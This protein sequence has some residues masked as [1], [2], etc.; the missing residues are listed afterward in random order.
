LT[1]DYVQTVVCDY[2]QQAGLKDYHGSKASVVTVEDLTN[3]G[4]DVSNATQLDQLR[5][6][7]TIPCNDVK[8]VFINM[9]IGPTAQIS[10]QAVWYSA[11]D[12]DY[13]NVSD[14]PIE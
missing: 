5:V 7:V 3:P 4:T 1:N 14:P 6:T 13:P 12:K 10:G 8:W 11:K 9:F 2:L